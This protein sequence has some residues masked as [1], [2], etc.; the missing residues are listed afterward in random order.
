MNGGSKGKLERLLESFKVAVD[1]ERLV[2]C[3]LG[4]SGKSRKCSGRRAKPPKHHKAG[5][6][7]GTVTVLQPISFSASPSRLNKL[8]VALALILVSEVRRLIQT[9]LL[10][11]V[12]VH[13]HTNLSTLFAAPV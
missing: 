7:I 5:A 8:P 10:P 4:S 1:R 9:G 2:G 3:H 11:Y 6:R 13:S 12:Q